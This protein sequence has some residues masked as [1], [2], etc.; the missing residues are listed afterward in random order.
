MDFDHASNIMVVSRPSARENQLVRGSGIVK[1]CMSERRVAVCLCACVS[2]CA[3]V[4][5]CA[6]ECACVCV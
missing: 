5:A 4:F 6:C 2:V 3:C 1:V